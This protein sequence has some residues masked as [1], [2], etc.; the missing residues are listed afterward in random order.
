MKEVFQKMHTKLYLL[1]CCL[2]HVSANVLE[3]ELI[4]DFHFSVTMKISLNCYHI[5]TKKLHEAQLFL[6]QG[7]SHLSTE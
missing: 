4:H 3:S 7:H 5:G 2:T 1:G 6:S